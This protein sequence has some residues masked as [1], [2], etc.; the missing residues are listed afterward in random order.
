MPRWVSTDEGKPCRAHLIPVPANLA[1][2]PA[3]QASLAASV[4]WPD[5]GPPASRRVAR[6][7]RRGRGNPRNRDLYR[8]HRPRLAPGQASKASADS[9]GPVL[10]GSRRAGT[11]TTTYLWN[12]RTRRITAILGY[13]LP[14]LARSRSAR[15]GAPLP[16]AS[17][18]ATST[19]GTQRTGDDQPA[20]SAE[21][22]VAG[23]DG[24]CRS[25]RYR[26]PRR[27]G[28]DRYERPELA[29]RPKRV[30]TSPEHQVND[31]K[32]RRA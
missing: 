27:P 3:V 11:G 15:T 23:V 6:D 20:P 22:D 24:R 5:F 25:G 7:R 12:A 30:Q 31:G 17:T 2:S 8:G 19:C 10:L 28:R 1:P 21:E 32:V 4:G 9:R 26:G 16:W 29:R 13:P 14:R 18:T